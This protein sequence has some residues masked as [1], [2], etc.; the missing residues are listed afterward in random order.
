M[1]WLLPLAAAAALAGCAPKVE[2]AACDDDGNCPAGQRCG[3]D[4]T[5]SVAATSCQAAPNCHET[6][7][8]GKLLRD[9]VADAQGLCATFQ[10]TTCQDHQ[11]CNAGMGRCDCEATACAAGVGAYCAL[12]GNLVTCATEAGTGCRY[13]AS[14]APCEPGRHCAGAPA[15]AC[16]CPVDGAG[17]DGG[18]S[19]EAVGATTCSGN[20]LLTC[21]PAVADST[22]KVWRLAEDCAAAGLTCT[23]GAPAACTCPPPAAS[24]V[25]RHADPSADPAAASRPGLAPSGA[26]EPPFCRYPTLAAALA[27]SAQG[28]QVQAVGYAGTPVV[29]TEPALTV[30]RGVT[31]FTDDAAPT[32]A[33]YV[34][35]PDPGVG[36]AAAVTLRP[37]A[38]LRGFE[39]RNAVATGAGIATDCADPADTEV[40]SILDVQVTGLGPGP[41]LARFANGLRHG[42]YCPLVL[43]ASTFTGANDGGVLVADAD[44]A[45]TLTMTDNRVASNQANVTKYTIGAADRRGGGIVFLRTLPGTVLFRGNK[46]LGNAGDQV[47]VFST[48]AL[49]LSGLSCDAGG[50]ANTFACYASGVGVSS[51][52][53]VV[54]A[55]YNH[56]QATI[57]TPGVD[58]LAGPGADVAGASTQACT[59]SS[60]TCP[61]P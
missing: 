38:T 52:A 59:V 41:G 12:D 24:P 16:Q 1:R 22:C 58:Y 15:A 43:R 61:A 7:C 42:G 49:D 18:C 35:E 36:S 46:V 55:A 37:L 14:S 34:I 4:R 29:F 9:C 3:H 25:V 31:L 2:G 17:V 6:V 26:L 27:V 8:D 11:V 45:A 19:A 50:A 28:D 33:H 40:V 20:A 10:D 48:S 39:V 54:N 53:S 23:A 60:E 51:K 13:E 44:P 47:L 30:P 57:P 21:Q 56:W 32:P 5:C